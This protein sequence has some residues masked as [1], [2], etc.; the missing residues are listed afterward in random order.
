MPEWIGRTGLANQRVYL[1]FAG[2]F[3]LVEDSHTTTSKLIWHPSLPDMIHWYF[4]VTQMHPLM[5]FKFSNDYQ[6][7]LRP[8][9]SEYS[10]SPYDVFAPVLSFLKWSEIRN[11]TSETPRRKPPPPKSPTRTSALT[12]R[13]LEVEPRVAERLVPQRELV[14]AELHAAPQALR[15]AEP[16]VRELAREL[17]AHAAQARAARGVDPD[18]GRQLADDRPEVARLEPRR[19]RQRAV[20]V[21]FVRYR[22]GYGS[23]KYIQETEGEGRRKGEGRTF[24]AWGPRSR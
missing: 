19:G 6:T 3:K 9:S 5:T 1:S 12:K 10:T 16:V 14:L 24:R 13:L 17:E 22:Y 20:V 21:V 8:P 11:A 23:A 15:H 18:R 7:S 4:V 2:G